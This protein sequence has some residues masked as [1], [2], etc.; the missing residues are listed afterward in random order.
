MCAKV[1]KTGAWEKGAS[2]AGALL[3]SLDAGDAI[4][5]ASSFSHTLSLA[6]NIAEEVQMRRR[7]AAGRRRAGGFADETLRRLVGGLGETPERCS[8]RQTID[9]VLTAHPTLDDMAAVSTEE[10]RSVMFRA[11]AAP[12]GVLPCRDAG[13]DQTEHGQLNTGSQPPKRRPG[14]GGNRVPFAPSRGGSS[15]GR[16]RGSTSECGWASALRSGMPR[17]GPPRRPGSQRSG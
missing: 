8:T 16:R 11:R 5:V 15:R 4:M 12:R 10:Y 3:T 14:G 1:P 9:I 13:D 6:N 7:S 17:G 2:F